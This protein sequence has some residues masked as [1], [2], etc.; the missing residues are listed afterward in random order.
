[1]LKLRTKI[2]IRG[3]ETIH[4][5]GVYIITVVTESHSLRGMCLC[6]IIINKLSQV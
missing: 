3:P 4:D 5:F 2:N 1:M 6:H